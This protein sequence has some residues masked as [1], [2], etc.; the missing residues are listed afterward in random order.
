MHIHVHVQVTCLEKVISMIPEN[1]NVKLTLKAVTKRTRH[2]THFDLAA[3]HLQMRCTCMTLCICICS[4]IEPA[5][6]IAKMSCACSRHTAMIIVQWQASNPPTNWRHGIHNNIH[7]I[8]MHSHA[9]IAEVVART[10]TIST[11]TDQVCMI[12]AL[13]MYMYPIIKRMGYMYF[14]AKYLQQYKYHS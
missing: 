5:P 2:A 7:S 4:N 3:R 12:M 11:C 10:C 9:P 14:P 8:H 1:R 13:L 6:G